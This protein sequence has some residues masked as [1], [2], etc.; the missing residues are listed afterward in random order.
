MHEINCYVHYYFV[1]YRLLWDEWE[2]FITRGVD[3]DTTPAIPEW[4]PT[5][6]A[7]G[8]LWDYFAFPT[9]ITPTGSLP[10]T[11]P[12]N[13]YN[14]IYNEYYRNQN[15]QSE[16]SLTN[17]DVKLRNWELDYLTSALPFQQRGTP[18]ALPVSGTSSAVFPT[19]SFVNGTVAGVSPVTS[20]LGVNSHIY[21]NNANSRDNMELVFNDNTV[22][23]SGATTVDITDLRLA[24]QLQVWMERNARA[25]VRYIEFLRAH[26]KVA[27]RDERLDRPEYIGG[28]KAPVII[29]EVLQ[30]S[31]TDVV[32]PQGNMAGHGLTVGSGNIGNYA[33]EEFGLIMGIMSV[34]PRTSYQNGVNK[35]FVR[36]TN[37]DYFSPEFTL[38]SEQAVLNSEVMAKDGDPTYNQTIFGYQ[39]R[40]NEMRTNY[41]TVCGD[42]RDLFDYWHLGRQFTPGSP[43]SLND[44]FIKCDVRKDIFAVP[45]E[46][47]LIV[48]QGNIIKASR[49][50]PTEG[51]PGGFS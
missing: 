37:Y 10:N 40:Y 33:V 50:L 25:G 5:N 39:G 30:T 18:P 35:N 24:F 45:S 4:T 48:D 47:G 14:F 23:L 8:S 22:D 36:P 32:T 3:G 26:Y 29:S 31:S 43:P 2:T 20:Q 27:P 15:L 41:N 9:T 17:E 34:M 38:L 19:S 46:P 1:P 44:D 12:M 28:H 16:I 13:A 51:I 6:K 42:M 49:P 7:K 21:S 11:F